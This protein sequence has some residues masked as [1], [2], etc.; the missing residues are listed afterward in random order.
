M[1]SFPGVYLSVRYD[2]ASLSCVETGAYCMVRIGVDGVD[3]VDGCGWV[4]MGVD[5]VDGAAVCISVVG[6][7]ESRI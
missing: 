5:G 1:F 2:C 6:G 4:W 3:G 7:R